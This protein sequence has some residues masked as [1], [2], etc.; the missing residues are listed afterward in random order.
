MDI[1]P[2]DP[3]AKRIAVVLLVAGVVMG[4]ALMLLFQRARP[5]FAAWILADEQQVAFR[6]RMVLA[7]VAIIVAAPS[8]AFGAYFYR[9]GA[10]TIRSER[11]PP[12]DT[13]MLHHTPVLTGEAARA[14]GRALEAIGCM[15]VIATIGIVA[16]LWLLASRARIA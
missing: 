14:R 9:L 5:Q 2:A 3:R 6:A 1:H 12:P 16:L 8:M 10:L 4:A 11:F 13:A 15:L 7:G